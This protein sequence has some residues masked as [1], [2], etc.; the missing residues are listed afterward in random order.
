MITATKTRPARGFTLIELLVVIAIIAILAAMLL[1][2]L[3]KA[4]LTS[5]KASCLN[6]LHQLGFAMFLY[7]DENDGVLPR[8]NDPLWWKIMTTQLGARNIGDYAKVKVFICPSYPDKTQCIC[9]VVN[10]WQFTTLTDQV[11]LEVTGLTKM[12]AIQSPA[13]TIYFADNESGSTRPIINE[14]TYN[15]VDTSKQD[16]WSPNHLPY[17][18]GGNVLNTADRRVASARHGVGPNLVFFDGHAAWKKAL[19]VI[20]D[21]WHS[22]RH[23]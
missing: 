1:P 6:N 19:F 15:S 23:N 12:N 14:Q 9:Y 20:P 8:G 3:T 17:A 5:Q 18:S 4:K 22:Q 13:Q 21:D 11:G 7:A 2:A 10:A 16:V